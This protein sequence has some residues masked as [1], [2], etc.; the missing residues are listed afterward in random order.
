MAVAAKQE[1]TFAVVTMS[2]KGSRGQREDTSGAYIQSKLSEEGYAF[3]SYVIIPDAVP[4]IIRTLNGLCD[5]DEVSLIVTT[6]GTGVA[7]TDVTPE[8]MLEVI[9]KEIP[10]MAEAMRFESLKKT[11]NAMLSRGKV[12]IRGNSLIINLPGSLKAVKENLDVVLPVLPHAL[13]KIRGDKGDCGK[14][15]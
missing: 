4:G 5:S 1:F 7:P 9:E 11:P 10:G 13:E 2:D 14:N 3:A 15:Q 12:G 6:G 8:A